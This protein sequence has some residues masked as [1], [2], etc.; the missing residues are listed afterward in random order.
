MVCVP[1]VSDNGRAQCAL[2]WE[3]RRFTWIEESQVPRPGR[4]IKGKRQKNSGIPSSDLLQRFPITISIENAGNISGRERKTAT[5]AL[6]KLHNEH[7]V[8]PWL[9]SSE[10]NWKPTY[11][12]EVVIGRH[13]YLS[14]HPEYVSSIK[15]R[16]ILC[17]METQLMASTFSN[18]IYTTI[19]WYK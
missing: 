6:E 15:G 19:H 10:P 8:W 13:H 7:P 14:R 3:N 18:N 17:R 9:R 16:N 2:G 1:N 4:H 12:D 11:V 5:H